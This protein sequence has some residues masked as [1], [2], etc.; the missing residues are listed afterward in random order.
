MKKLLLL[1]SLFGFFLFTTGCDDDDDGVN[2]DDGSGEE[3]FG[4]LY[5]AYFDACQG[6]EVVCSE[7]KESIND[8]EDLY[9]EYKS[10]I[11]G[12]ED[13]EYYQGIKTALEAEREALDC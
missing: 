10:C 3:Q 11:E 8:I 2:C 12:S 13:E 9:N 1:M 7:C 6:N 4:N 5:A